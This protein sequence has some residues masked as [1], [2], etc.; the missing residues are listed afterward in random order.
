MSLALRSLYLPHTGVVDAVPI[1]APVLLQ[2]VLSR[3]GQGYIGLRRDCAS[4]VA[5][6]GW[7]TVRVYSVIAAA[8]DDIGDVDSVV[9]DALGVEDLEGVVVAD[10][11]LT[12][13]GF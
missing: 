4:T 5:F 12:Q 1:L 11:L 13:S 7:R 9:V 2:T 3:P 8:L 10:V 6:I